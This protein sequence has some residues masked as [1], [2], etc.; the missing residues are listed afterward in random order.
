MERFLQLLKHVRRSVKRQRALKYHQRDECHERCDDAEYT[1]TDDGPYDKGSLTVAAEQTCTIKHQSIPEEQRGHI[2]VELIRKEGV[3]LGMTISGGIDKDHRPCMSGLQPG[4][5][6]ARSD[7]L[8]EGDYIKSVNGINLSRLR[9]EEIVTL[10]NNVGERITLDIEYELPAVCNTSGFIRKSTEITLYKECNTFG[11]VIRG[12]AHEQKLKSRPIVV[13]RI[14]AGGPADR[15]GSLRSGD[16]LLGVDGTSLHGVSHGDALVILQKCSVEAG[17]Q[18]EY[19]VSIMDTVTNPCGPLLVEIARTAGTNL[20]ITLA[21]PTACHK[22]IIVIDKIKRA[23]ISDRCGVLHSGDQMLSIDGISMDNCS[24]LEAAQLLGSTCGTIKLEVLPLQHKWLALNA[25]EHALVCATFSPTSLSAHCLRQTETNIPTYNSLPLTSPHRSTTCRRHKDPEFRSSLSLSSSTIGLGGQVVHPETIELALR[26]TSHHPTFGLSLQGS[27]FPN[28]VL[29]FPPVIAFLEPDSPAERCGLLQLGDR[30]VGVNGISTR[31]GT[32]DEAHQLLRDAAFVGS[33]VLEVEVDVAESIIPSSG[34]FHVKLVKRR[35]I[36]LGI[37]LSAQ[38]CRKF[39]EPLIIADIKK[40][41]IAHRIGSLSPGDHL[42]A[43]D[44]ARLD[45]CSTEEATWLLWNSE[46]LVHL[47]VQKN[48]DSSDEMDSFSSITYTVELR[49]YG[50]P[51]GITISGTEEPFDPIIISALTRGGLADR[52]GAIHIGDQILAINGLNLKNKP[53]SDAIRLLQSSGETVTLKIRKRNM[54][55]PMLGLPGHVSELSDPDEDVDSPRKSGK[56]C[57][58]FSA[59]TSVDS[60][61]ESWDSSGT[62]SGYGT[63]AALR[64]QM[65]PG[66]TLTTDWR[67]TRPRSLHAAE[68]ILGREGH[69]RSSESA[70]GDDEWESLKSGFHMPGLEHLDSF[71]SQALEDLETCGQSALLRELEASIMQSG[72]GDGNTMKESVEKDE[73]ELNAQCGADDDTTPLTPLLATAM[74]PWEMKEFQQQL[75]EIMAPP[76]GELHKVTL[77]KKGHKDFGFSISDGLLDK[78]VCINSLSPSGPADKQGALQPFDWI[79]QVNGVQ[80]QSFDCNLLVPLVT[81]SGDVLHLVVSRNQFPS[82]DHEASR[83]T[84][85]S[86]LGRRSSFGAKRCDSQSKE[87]IAI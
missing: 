49:R 1:Y 82:C 25:P 38:V 32:L 51:L 43:I 48:D 60:A 57:S 79:L 30:I 73:G 8:N 47:R 58:P 53:L 19:D 84:S 77:C 41:S 50:G 64:C 44:E 21:S 45:H 14:R 26:T 81:T 42:L 46:D 33:V 75:E 39:G 6:A 65:L 71:W 7:Q 37:V 66:A 22:P 54:G 10:L 9:H 87:A 36:D 3:Q 78:G 70:F 63:Q 4:G 2:T 27:D 13:S 12:G 55:L 34:T 61:M 15:E 11:F 16:R 62:D 40:G 76:P 85:W 74:K 31:D 29:T 17:L 80:V 35:G 20:G 59:V 18:I 69:G 83:T 72:N 56:A 23:S 5:I 24:V 28:E 52:T 68:R 86:P 67:N